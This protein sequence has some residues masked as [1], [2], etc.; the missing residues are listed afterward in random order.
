MQEAFV[1]RIGGQ[2]II[3]IVKHLHGVPN[4]IELFSAADAIAAE[5]GPLYFNLVP[6]VLRVLT[7]DF[8]LV[9]GF[10]I[11]GNTYRLY[12]NPKVVGLAHNVKRVEVDLST[13][14]PTPLTNEAFI[15]TDPFI[16]D[17]RTGLN[18]NR[19]YLVYVAPSGQNVY[20][21]SANLGTSWGDE[22]P[23]DDVAATD[24]NFA[25]ANFNDPLGDKEDVQVLQRRDD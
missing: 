12:W 10:T 7:Q 4:E 17:A 14:I 22:V 3:H 15:A 20:R 23:I 1:L 19:L 24:H 16:M 13:L 21:V 8:H 5:S 11:A 2:S 25:E 18:P 9:S 6:S